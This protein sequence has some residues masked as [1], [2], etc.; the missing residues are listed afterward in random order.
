MRVSGIVLSGLLMSIAVVSIAPTGSAFG[1][2]TFATDPRCPPDAAA[3]IGYRWSYPDPYYTCQYK[4]PKPC[5]GWSC[6]PPDPCDGIVAC[7][8]LYWNCYPQP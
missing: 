5:S 3:C 4:V 6:P 1:W 7:P 8:C 2:C